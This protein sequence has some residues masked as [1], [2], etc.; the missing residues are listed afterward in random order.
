[1]KRFEFAR[2][3]S[4]FKWERPII[5]GLLVVTLALAVFLSL[6]REVREAEAF[7]FDQA[8]LTELSRIAST[9]M[10][11]FMLFASDTAAPIFFVPALVILAF[12]WL[13]HRPADWIALTAS[14]GGAFLLNQLM[15]SIFERARPDLFPHLQE[16]TGYSFPS[17]HSQAAMAFFPVL[18]YLIARRV[19]PPW[20]IPIYIAAGLWVIL[21]GLSRNYL[22]V[23]YP[24]DVLAAFAVTLPWALT[25][26][27]VHRC[28]APP[29]RPQPSPGTAPLTEP[30]AERTIPKS[31]NSDMRSEERGG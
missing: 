10:T 23:H 7:G 27:F 18:A 11:R 14:V 30:G 5:V 1:M 9:N 13:R 24:S 31:G 17:G 20:R 19:R 16:V 21:V 3:R 22:E 8:I 25:V 26:I 2:L 29:P 28:Y 6:A 4:C 12:F 15:K